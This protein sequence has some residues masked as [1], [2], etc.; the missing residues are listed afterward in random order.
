MITCLAKLTL[1]S[2]LISVFSHVAFADRGA[3]QPN[4][5]LIITDDQSWDTLGFM[6]GN[7]LT[8][9]I[10]KMAA[11]GLYLTDFNVTSTVCSPSRYS[12]LTGRYAGNSRGEKFMKEHP[13]GD[14]TQ[15]ENIGELEPNLWNLPKLLQQNGYKTGFVG[16]SH[17]IHH[18]WIN[19]NWERAGFEV[20]AQ[21]ADPRKPEV[22]AQ[23]RRN[24]Q[25]WCE[26]MKPFGF[27]FV[28]G[29]YS[30]NL[31]ELRNDALNVHNLDWTVAKA[32]DF[33]DQSKEEPFF[34]YFSTTLHHGPAPWVNKF[35]MDADPRMTGEGF[36]KEGFD[37]I[38]T[39][40]DVRRRNREAGLKDN[41]AF[42]LW[43]DD[44]VG[45]IIDKVE[46]LGL[47]EDTLILFVPDHGSYRHG[48]ATL[49]DYG[50]RVPML[51]LW[52]GKI[53]PGTKYDE[54]VANIDLAPTLLDL[55]G[56]E[57][58]ADYQIDGVSFKDALFGS[59]KPLREILFAEMGHSRG[60]KTK[61]WKYI[62]V[63]YPDDLQRKIDNGFR[64]KDFRGNPIKLPFLTRNSHLG[65]F[66][67]EKNPH[68]FDAD[69]L[70]SLKNDPEETVN[71]FK[72]NPEVAA[73]LQKALAK[74]LAKFVDRPFGEF[75]R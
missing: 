12:F 2:L 69:Q 37:V 17:L 3:K 46:S 18:E 35:G 8:P 1:F 65:H 11:D 33:L 14:Q 73:E 26:A 4:V 67:A 34:L 22:N 63:R 54:I 56:I 58:P 55:C 51:C 70:Y 53:R 52:K 19:G 39:R 24:H 6:G 66:A 20:Y 72:R 45:T 23:M 71:L 7:V 32:I 50:M 28:D 5:I 41:K 49:H 74:E 40:A 43:L 42:A 68:Y 9:R 44:G 15:V 27:D 21:N 16:K 48:K 60:V 30:A 38:P 62:A 10:D 64:F 31:K 59:Q 29:Y 61:D 13:V 75:T 47:I 36:V 57:T 25:K